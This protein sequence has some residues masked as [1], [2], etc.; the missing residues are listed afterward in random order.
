MR[1]RSLGFLKRQYLHLNWCREEARKLAK[2]LIEAKETIKLLNERVY[3]L[4]IENANLRKMQL[5]NDL[6]RMAA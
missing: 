1:K 6:K 4:Q 3:E 5:E 2:N